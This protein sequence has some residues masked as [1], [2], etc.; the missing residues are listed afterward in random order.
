M[1]GCV[2]GVL[3]GSEIADANA[4]VRVDAEDFVERKDDRRRSRD[5]RAADD[6]NLALVNVAAPNG[7]AAIDDARNAKHKTE[8]HDYGEAV[9]DA[10]LEVGGVEPR[11]LREG[12]HGVEGEDGGDHEERWQPR[13][14]FGC[15]FLCELH[16]VYVFCFLS[17]SGFSAEHAVTISQAREAKMYVIHKMR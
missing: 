9:A 12:R 5:D 13:V 11:A 4:A 1:A 6:G 8:H 7:E 3:A 2:A 14:D 16:S 15:N 17:V 10:G